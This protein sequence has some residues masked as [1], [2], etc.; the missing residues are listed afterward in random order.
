MGRLVVVDGGKAQ[1]N[2]A[3]HVLLKAGMSIPVVA[4]TKDEHHRPKRIVGERRI[5]ELHEKD[6]LLA[7]AEAHR[8]ALRYH[9]EL[10]RKKFLS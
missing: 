4:V 3:E 9:K 8:F 7:N 5:T 10:R 1:K 2:A 6:I